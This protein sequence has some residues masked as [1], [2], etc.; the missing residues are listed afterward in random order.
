MKRFVLIALMVASASAVSAQ[1]GTPTA[2]PAQTAPQQTHVLV[3]AIGDTFTFVRQ[4]E[5]VGSNIIDNFQ[6]K[7]LKVP[8]NLF[9]N[10][11]LRGLDRAVAAEF[12]NSKR[13]LMSLA[14][15]E[16]EGVLPQDREKVAIG[17]LTSVLDKHPDRANWDRIYIVTP[18][19]LLSER[20]GMGTKLQGLGVY[21]QPLTGGS[22]QTEGSAE[23][24]GAETIDP[25]TSGLSDTLDP[26]GEGTKSKVYVAPYSYLTTYVLDAKTMRVIE[27]N[28][29]HDFRK[30]Y[31]PKSTALDV[32]NNIDLAF[33]GENIEGLVERSVMRSVRDVA[34]KARVE[35]GD[36]KPVQPQGNKPPTK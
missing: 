9:N 5:S 36:V 8:N 11:A 31:D 13:I 26:D 3:S 30:L 34:D 10:I 17:K 18:K 33:L 15:A 21:V 24:G 16:L 27:K 23:G 20:E 14:P 29:R 32:A 19:F 25:S 1:T 12:P 28:T 6:R 22:L 7:V 4:R 2:T 35:I